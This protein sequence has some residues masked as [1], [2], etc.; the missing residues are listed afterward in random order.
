[1]S[2]RSIPSLLLLLAAGPA[3]ASSRA[4]DPTTERDAGVAI[5]PHAQIQAGIATV[6]E[7]TL[8]EAGDAATADGV[9]IRR[10][11]LGLTADANDRV[12]AEITADLLG[13]AARGGSGGPLL[14][15]H[16]T[17]MVRPW[18]GVDVGLGKVPF[19]ASALTS[20]AR[21]ALPDRPFA[22]E[23]IAPDRRAGATL[24]F[25]KFVRLAAGVY[26]VTADPGRGNEAN[27]QMSAGRLEWGM[28]GT[29]GREETG[30]D[31]GPRATARFAIGV[32]VF[33]ARE[34]DVTRN[35][36]TADVAFRWRRF[37]LRA[38]ALAE[39]AETSAQP[40]L[41]PTLPAN[42]ESRGVYAQAAAQ[43]WP[44]WLEWVVRAEIDDDRVGVDDAGDAMVLTAG[45]N[46][47]PANDLLRGQLAFTH[48][49]ETEAP[50]LS[51]DSLLYQVQVSF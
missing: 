12:R 30:F 34:A 28:G 40:E 27:G 9:R 21:L 25:D 17:M 7:D 18:F 1:M 33:H 44:N 14:D 50:E 41:P 51:N 11:R 32:G 39:R 19:S 43:L 15:A 22:V 8:V 6:G 29:M 48:R 46:L 2:E 10:A 35:G 24:M 26:N 13:D 4:A 49:E 37:S 3:L 36:H 5:A 16:I 20:S 38:G 45:L 23:R 42:A 47:Y 31:L